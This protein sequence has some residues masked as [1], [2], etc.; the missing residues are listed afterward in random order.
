MRCPEC[1]RGTFVLESRERVQG[2]LR[3][4]ECTQGHRFYT[5]EQPTPAPRRGRRVNKGELTK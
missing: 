4:R 2:Y 3:R 5:V 1:G